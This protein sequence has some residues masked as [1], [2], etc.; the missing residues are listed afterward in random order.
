MTRDLGVHVKPTV[1]KKGAQRDAFIPTNDVKWRA[2]T[3]STN[4]T[5]IKIQFAKTHITGF[6]RCKKRRVIDG[7]TL[8][9]QRGSSTRSK[10]DG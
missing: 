3:G 8:L 2:R 6:G 7:T 9:T 1:E 5:R 4:N 10:T